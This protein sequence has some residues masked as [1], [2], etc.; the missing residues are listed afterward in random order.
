MRVSSLA[1]FQLAIFLVRLKSILCLFFYEI[2]KIA[3]S[4]FRNTKNSI[5]VML[6][7]QLMLRQ[8][9]CTIFKEI[10]TGGPLITRPL[11]ARISLQHGFRKIVFPL[12]A[13]KMASL[14]H[15][16]TKNSLQ[17]S[18]STDFSQ[19]GFLLLPFYRA[20]RGPPVYSKKIKKIKFL[21]N[22]STNIKVHPLDQSLLFIQLH[23]VLCLSAVLLLFNFIL[24][25][26]IQQLKITLLKLPYICYILFTT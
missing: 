18:H 10:T 11:I 24:C 13:R 7:Q 12:I 8:Q 2:K 5:G 19:H 3:K 22:R 9:P 14:Q 15:N 6:E 25:T 23:V 26:H 21:L 17:Y 16:F 1:Q 20:M 4:L